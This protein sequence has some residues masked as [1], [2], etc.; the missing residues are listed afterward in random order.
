MP[1]DEENFQR[2]V[3]INRIIHA[4][5]NATRHDF[6]KFEILPNN[7]PEKEALRAKIARS[8]QIQSTLLQEHSRLVREHYNNIY[9]NSL[10]RT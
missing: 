10:A 9:C 4:M 5:R 1:T 8:L 7:H 2:V 3:V 6:D